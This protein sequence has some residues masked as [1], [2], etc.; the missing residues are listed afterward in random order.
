MHDRGNIPK[1]EKLIYLQNAIQDKTAKSM[2]VGF[3][4]S[5]DHYDEAVKCL[6]ERYDW[7]RQIHQMHVHRI[8]EAP[9]LRDGTGKEIRALH[10][11][12]VQHLRALK[13]LGH[14]P[15]RAFITSLLEM[16]LDPNTMFEWQRHSQDHTDVPDCQE[17]LDFLNLR[18]QA[19]EASTEKKRVSKP[20]NSMVISAS[21][22]NCISCGEERHQ[23]YA[24]TKFR[25][26]SHAEKTDLLRSK[27]YCLNCL[28]P[29]HFVKQCKSLNHCKRCQRPHHT[30]LHQEK[31][32]APARRNTPVTTVTKSESTTMHVFINSNMLLMTRQ[33]MVETPQGVVKARALL[34]TESSASFVTV[35]LAQSLHLRQFTQNARIC[36]IAGIPHSDGKQAVVQFLVSSA[37]SPGVRYNVNAFIIPQITGDQPICMISPD[38]NW[39]HLEGLT[40]ADP[41]YNQPGGIDILLGVETLVEVIR[42]SRRSGPHN[43]PTALDTALD[44][45]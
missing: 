13:S 23:L 3:T 19:A 24:C 35:R 21:V 34:D 4:K 40:L 29:G 26:L 18:A 7:P 15:S 2:I 30:L 45:S 11:L 10:D 17:L 14:E 44:W 28:R 20:V 12:V 42:H 22:N 32:D 25:S 43:T 37:H 9:S 8:V 36:G 6:Q 5:S 1:E 16:K 31:E 33:V 41:D 27:N 39:K 38:R